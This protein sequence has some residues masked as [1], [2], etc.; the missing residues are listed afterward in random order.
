[1]ETVAI[2]ASRAMP[3]WFTGCWG[4]AASWGGSGWCPWGPL[5]ERTPRHGRLGQRGAGKN[6][7]P[8][9]RRGCHW[10]TGYRFV[11]SRLAPFH[12]EVAWFIS[13]LGTFLHAMM[14]IF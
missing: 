13:S 4:R 7:R 14:F 1:M 12:A 2:G 10:E 11:A 8:T 5:R 3:S 9:Q 6:R